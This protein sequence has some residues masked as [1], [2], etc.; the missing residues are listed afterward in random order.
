LIDSGLAGVE[1]SIIGGGED[2]AEAKE[3]GVPGVPGVP[4]SPQER[5]GK[6]LTL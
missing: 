3:I 5:K 6:D 2:K 1:G 4:D